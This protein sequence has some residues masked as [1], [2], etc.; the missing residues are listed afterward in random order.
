MRN[1]PICLRAILLDLR[2]GTGIIRAILSMALYLFLVLLVSGVSGG[3]GGE[4][5]TFNKNK[6]SSQYS[7]HKIKDY[8]RYGGS[9]IYSVIICLKKSSARHKN[10]K[11]DERRANSD[12]F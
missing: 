7:R 10:C 1:L 3:D 6:Y 9:E 2:T 4:A 5:E 12:Y 11:A 8:H